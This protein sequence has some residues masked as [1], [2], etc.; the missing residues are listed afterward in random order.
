MSDK[1]AVFQDYLAHYMLLDGRARCAVA[2]VSNTTEILKRS[3]GLD[4]MTTIA[5]GR[6]LACV[7]LLGS[8]LKAPA[9]FLQLTFTGNGPMQKVVAECTGRGGLR[10][11]VRV[12]QLASVIGPG[13]RVPETVGEAL[14]S[15]GTVRVVE[16]RIDEQP[17]TSIAALENGEIATDLARYLSD[18]EQVPSAVAAGVKLDG[19]GNVLGAGGVLVQKLGGGELTEAELQMLEQKLAAINISE[20]IAAG[21]T[22]DSI[23][24]Y[25][26]PDSAFTN[27][28]RRH[29]VMACTCSRKKIKKMLLHLG[30]E[31]IDDIRRDV[32]KVEVRCQYCGT[33]YN[34]K[35]GEVA[36]ENAE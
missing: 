10:G 7:A 4:P 6:A 15:V 22:V 28:G 16:G 5:L 32:G 9:Q 1:A 31:E 24:E 3:H 27:L 25:L 33:A 36:G 19:Q 29:L 8:K 11:Y 35:E 23:C 17:Q 26:T 34:F 18:S 12:P 14:G 21:F 13:D 2:V 20:R 30:Q